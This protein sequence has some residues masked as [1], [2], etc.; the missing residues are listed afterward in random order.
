MTEH[1]TEYVWVVSSPC[2]C[3]DPG[4][5][6]VSDIKVFRSEQTAK[7]EADLRSKRYHGHRDRPDMHI[8][9]VAVSTKTTGW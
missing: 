5:Y 2:D 4:C 7:Q 9:K 8:E 3:E 1:K 6:G